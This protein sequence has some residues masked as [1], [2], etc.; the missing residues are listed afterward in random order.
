MSEDKQPDYSDD[1]MKA[2]RQAD[3]VYLV[4]EDVSALLNEKRWP[5]CRRSISNEEDWPSC[6]ES[7]A[8]ISPTSLTC[9]AKA[10]PECGAL[11]VDEYARSRTDKYQSVEQS[12]FMNW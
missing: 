8:N 4:G 12:S 6:V 11:L 7:G 5:K 10:C 1:V 2:L 9:R 3:G